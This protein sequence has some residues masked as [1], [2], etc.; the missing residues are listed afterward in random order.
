VHTVPFLR[1]FGFRGCSPLASLPSYGT[2]GNIAASADAGRDASPECTPRGTAPNGGAFIF[3][4]GAVRIAETP[5]PGTGRDFGLIR[6][7]S[8]GFPATSPKPSAQ[9]M[10]GVHNTRSGVH[11][12]PE[13]PPWARRQSEKS[14]LRPNGRVLR[15]RY[16]TL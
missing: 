1:R 10:R 8:I 5:K 7:V 12:T 11:N 3:I 15:L 4:R 16:S 14:Y 6:L 13:R 9:V 2:I